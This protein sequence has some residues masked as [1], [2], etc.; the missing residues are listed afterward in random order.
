MSFFKQ[1]YKAKIARLNRTFFMDH[2]IK[3]WIVVLVLFLISSHFL[4]M[5]IYPNSFMANKVFL[6]V[7]LI[8]MFYIWIQELKDRRR[9][10][11]LNKHLLK[12]RGKLERAEIDMIAT[13]ILTAEAKDPYTHGHSK[14]VAEYTSAIAKEM[15]LPA[16]EQKLIERAAILHDLGKIGI[17]DDILRKDGKLNDEQ[18]EIMKGHPR[19]AIEILKPL[20]FLFKEKD[21]ILHHHETHD[22]S[23]YPDGLKGGSIPLGSQIIAVADT[24]DAMNTARSYRKALPRETIVSELK[25]ISGNQLNPKIVTT[26]LK[27][28]NADKKT[29]FK[30][31]E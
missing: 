22:G 15:K 3:T 14:R 21:I 7:I 29:A 27:L 6:T 18:W 12:A 26:F 31:K 17:A 23:G 24:F 11:L 8:F 2:K 19:K 5:A 9:L 25:K 28:V 20:K 16:E 10:E 30:T 4:A 13:L 1:K